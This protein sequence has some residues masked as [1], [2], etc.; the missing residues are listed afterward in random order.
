M[1]YK[2]SEKKHDLIL[3]TSIYAGLSLLLFWLNRLTYLLLLVYIILFVVST[4]FILKS[5]VWSGYLYLNGVCMI[6]NENENCDA[7][8][9][10]CDKSME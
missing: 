8:C 1:P 4:Y 9:L 10:K 3:N 6:T 2:L 5:P 7:D